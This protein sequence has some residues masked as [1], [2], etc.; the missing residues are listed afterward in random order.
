MHCK[1]N[2]FGLYVLDIK[3]NEE[4]SQDSTVKYG[5]IIFTSCIKFSNNVPTNKQYEL[6]PKQCEKTWLHLD[7]FLTVL[8]KFRL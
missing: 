4:Y 3:S 7:A 5:S 1:K 2:G 6:F 8:F